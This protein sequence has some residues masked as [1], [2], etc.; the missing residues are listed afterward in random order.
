[1]PPKQDK[2]SDDPR[3]YIYGDTKLMMELRSAPYDPK[4]NVWAPDDKEC[5]IAVEVK[6]EKGDKAV[7]QLPKGA[8]S[9][10]FTL[11]RH[12]VRFVAI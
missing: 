3:V 12:F 2:I 10:K 5:F 11:K 4:K 7:V 1:M 8:V 6:E 9:T